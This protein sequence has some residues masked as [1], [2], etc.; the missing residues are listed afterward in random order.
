[1]TYDINYKK[2][3]KCGVLKSLDSYHKH[4]LMKDFH[5]NECKICHKINNQKWYSDNTKKCGLQQKEYR[6]KNHDK[7]REIEKKSFLRNREKRLFGMRQYIIKL[8]DF[9]YK[10]YGDKCDCCGETNREFFAIDHIN[11]GGTEERRKLG[12]R[13]ILIMASKEGFQKEKYRLLCHN[14]NMSLG[15]FGYCPHHPEIKRP[16]YRPKKS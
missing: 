10:M 6:I 3:N 9:V 16:I 15:F 13:G 1:M 8:K 7:V 12:T 2:C 14:C 5:S 11:G 4:K